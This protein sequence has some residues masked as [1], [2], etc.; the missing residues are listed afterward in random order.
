MTA[1]DA[2]V[3]IF[4]RLEA[5]YFTYDNYLA[6]ETSRLMD[7][8]YIHAENRPKTLKLV[9]S[10]VGEGANN[11][12]SSTF[13]G[14]SDSSTGAVD[15]GNYVFF[16]LAPST[17]GTLASAFWGMITDVQPDAQNASLT[18]LCD[19][20]TQKFE[21]VKSDK[22]IFT[23][24]RD[25][26][27]RDVDYTTAGDYHYYVPNIIDANI[28][29][30]FTKVEV[31][32]D[33]SVLQTSTGSNDLPAQNPLAQQ[34]VNTDADALFGIG[35]Y[36][37]TN[38]GASKYMTVAICADTG[39]G[40]PGPIIQS[41]TVLINN[42]SMTWYDVPLYSTTNPYNGPFELEPGRAYWIYFSLAGGVFADK[43]GCDTVNLYAQ[44]PSYDYYTGGA[45]VNSGAGVASISLKAYVAKFEQVDWKDCGWDDVND[46]LFMKLQNEIVSPGA[47]ADHFRAKVSYYYGLVTA[48]TVASSLTGLGQ[49]LSLDT[50]T[51]F[52]QAG[53]YLNS[54]TYPIWRVGSNTIGDSM[55]ELADNQCVY[56]GSVW[57]QGALGFYKSTYTPAGSNILKW[58]ARQSVASGSASFMT[59]SYGPGAMDNEARIIR[60]DLRKTAKRPASVCVIGKSPDGFPIVAHRDDRGLTTS[61][62]K[63]KTK[64]L[65]TEYI[66]DDNISTLQQ[67]DE[68]AKARLDMNVRD[69]WEGEIEISGT[70]PDMMDINPASNTFG[71]G[72]IVTVNYPLLGL[73]AQKFKV[74]QVRVTPDDTVITLSNYDILLENKYTQAYESAK[75]SETNLAPT[76]TESNVFVKFYNSAVVT[77]ST[78][79]MVLATPL[80]GAN[81]STRVL[82]T[83]MSDPTR[84]TN[85]YHAEFEAGNGVTTD[86]P[87]AF[88]GAVGLF[89]GL[90]GAAVAI[91]FLG[92]SYYFPKWTGTRVIVD[93]AVRDG[94]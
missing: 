44:S 67:A 15:I 55:R 87:S 3:I 47:W 90:T 4:N 94:T 75:R 80:G 72:N 85:I 58:S 35:F 39:A 36:A 25:A 43:M 63:T 71:S 6:P 88:V 66:T 54:K 50:P 8:E 9:I 5:G 7:W 79:Y 49:P 30:P 22:V 32:D 62:F 31:A 52:S 65:L 28:A 84:K 16:Q 53:T 13:N 42:A 21:G 86:S 68:I 2:S 56:T 33:D 70:Y 37:S 17:T 19:E 77:S 29:L 41:R 69:V 78:I 73:A 45:W 57:M 83:K 82:C 74:K 61:S 23:N 34:I 24:Y 91:G 1:G 10:N 12:L 93:F 14:W 46:R 48:A 26:Y 38:G 76:D 92:P 60:A 64:L 18:L 51:T 40:H 89:T 81:I 11:L 27:T 59:L 20:Y